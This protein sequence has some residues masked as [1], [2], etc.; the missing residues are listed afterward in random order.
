MA[1][2]WLL[3]GPPVCDFKDGP[4]SSAMSLLKAAKTEYPWPFGKEEVGVAGAAIVAMIGSD[5]AIFNEG[6]FN[7]SNIYFKF[8]FKHIVCTH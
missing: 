5:I 1:V 7:V 8:H 6:I 4:R 2:G 3:G